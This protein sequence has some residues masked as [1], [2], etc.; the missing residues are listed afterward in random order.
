M[1]PK[2]R[3]EVERPLLAYRYTHHFDYSA[4]SM[5]EA[6]EKK[7]GTALFALEPM[8]RE[9]EH[10]VYA[11]QVDRAQGDNNCGSVAHQCGALA[12]LKG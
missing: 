10:E 1:C 3:E 11:C 2:F 5:R 7:R 4:L 9:S 6:R 8:Q 12:L